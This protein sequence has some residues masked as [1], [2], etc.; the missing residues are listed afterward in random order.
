MA[1]VGRAARVAS[2]QRTETIT[3]DKQIVKGESG[4]YYLINH[5][6]ASTITVTLPSAEEGSYFKFLFTAALTNDSAA[7]KFLAQ[8]G[9]YL[10]GGPIAL[11][12]D[13]TDG[14]AQAVGN[15]TSNISMTVD[16]NTDVLQSSWVEFV[17]DGTKWHVSGLILCVD[18]AT[19]ASSIGFADS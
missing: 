2:R 9:E 12:G 4:E 16:G 7:V 10:L 19:V 15:G 3:A 6:A 18:G 14:G 17:S 1:K 11:N 13:A 8:A 5:D